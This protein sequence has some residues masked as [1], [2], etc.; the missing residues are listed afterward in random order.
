VRIRFNATK[1]SKSR[2]QPKYRK[3]IDFVHKYPH[4]DTAL[5]RLL[6]PLA[7]TAICERPMK[8]MLRGEY[9]A[10]LGRVASNREH[11]IG[12]SAISIV[13]ETKTTESTSGQ[14]PHAWI[15]DGSLDDLEMK[16]LLLRAVLVT[17]AQN[18]SAA[19]VPDMFG[20]TPFH[21]RHCTVLTNARAEAAVLTRLVAT[22]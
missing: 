11:D 2:Q 21:R 19:A 7:E 5:H 17:I 8:P 1:D 10:L 3:E 18:P 12:S 6:R 13:S 22:R 9:C 4:A 14:E 16:E 20:R 15:G